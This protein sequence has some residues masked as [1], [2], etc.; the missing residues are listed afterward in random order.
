MDPQSFLADPD[1]AV[2][3]LDTDP[4]PA[5]FLLGIGIQFK[6][7]CKKLTYGQFS[8]GDKNNKRLLQ[9]KK[10]HRAVPNLL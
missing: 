8:V 10:K 4:D 2:Y 9:S 6:K 7:L 3:F 5:A 1:A